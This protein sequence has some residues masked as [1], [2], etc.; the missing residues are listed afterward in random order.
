MNELINFSA[1]EVEEWLVLNDVANKE[2]Y[3][4]SL[5]LLFAFLVVLL[6]KKYRIPIVV[7]YV[8]LGILLSPDIISIFSVIDSETVN[9]YTF[10]LSNLDYVTNIALAFI[11]FTIGSEL[12]IKTLKRLGK[13]IFSIAI[14]ESVLAFVVVTAALYFIGRP[15]YMALLFGAIASATAPAATVMV[16]KEYNAEG[17]LTS[18]IMAVV[19]LDDAFALI[20]FSL[21]NPIAYSQY[22]G[23]GAIKLSEIIVLPL[24]EIFG[25]I[26][27]GLF[28]GYITQY[29]LTK[30]NEK[31]RKILTIV[32]SITLSSAVSIFFG[33]SAL[34]ANMSVGFAVRNFAKKNLEI[35]EEMDTLT[36]PLYAMFFIIAGTEIRFSEMGS[37]SFLLIAFTYLIAR[38]IGKVGGSTLAARISGAPEAVQKF[39]GFGLLPQSGVAIA[40]AYSVQKQ[41]VQDTKVGLLIFNTLLLTAAMTEVFG[42]LLTKYAV[43]QSGEGKID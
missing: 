37:L 19:G 40:L 41:Y 18:T 30:F 36:V 12:S 7:G 28:F 34:I 14:M 8:F 21:I 3:L 6:A 29:L 10:V 33:L 26:I 20:I 42:P 5:L 43:I 35:S 4:I 22:R 16:L 31:T 24:I 2:L 9:M 25:A 1:H 23:E 11:A 39:I 15:L 38:I 17:P 32:T 27:L 13:S